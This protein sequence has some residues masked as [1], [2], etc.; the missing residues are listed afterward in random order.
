MVSSTT[1]RF[2]DRLK[3][4]DGRKFMPVVFHLEILKM[5]D[6]LIDEQKKEIQKLKQKVNKLEQKL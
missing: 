4:I 5:R 1:I 2:E 3:T 6:S